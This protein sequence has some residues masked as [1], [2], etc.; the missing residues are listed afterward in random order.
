MGEARGVTADLMLGLMAKAKN[1]KR[2]KMKG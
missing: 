1:L 2:T